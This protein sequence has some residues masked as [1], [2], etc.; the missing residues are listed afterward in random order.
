MRRM[1][2]DQIQAIRSFGHQIRRPD[3]ADR[4]QEG[5]PFRA[6]DRRRLGNSDNRIRVRPGRLMVQHP[7]RLG[8]P[9]PSHGLAR[10]RRFF[11]GAR[12]RNR[13]TRFKRLADGALNRGEN[14]RRIAEAHLGFGRMHVDVHVL[15]RHLHEERAERIAAD[16]QQGVISLDHR[17]GQR[18][19][20]RS[21]GR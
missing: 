11:P 4:A 16:H 7:S 14:S 1:L 13:R 2:V 12:T 8:R 5:N 10:P 9:S 3:L 6:F 15:R 21:T 20:R 18:R 17:G 19:H